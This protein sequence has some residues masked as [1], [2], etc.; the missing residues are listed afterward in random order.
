M[1]KLFE[2]A[3]NRMSERVRILEGKKRLTAGEIPEEYLEDDFEAD[4]DCNNMPP[5]PGASTRGGVRIEPGRVRAG[6]GGN[7]G[8]FDVLTNRGRP[9]IG[10]RIGGKTKGRF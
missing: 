10:G 2:E 9:T 3:V 5:A 7:G 8:G 6:V 1:E 4:E